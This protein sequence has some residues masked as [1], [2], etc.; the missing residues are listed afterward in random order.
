MYI[1][2][3][4]VYCIYNPQYTNIRVRVFT[5]VNPTAQT[6]FKLYKSARYVNCGRVFIVVMKKYRS[7]GMPTTLPENIKSRKHCPSLAKHCT[8]II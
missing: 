2:Y 7:L 6:L 1:V 5:G 8:L 4:Y 3:I